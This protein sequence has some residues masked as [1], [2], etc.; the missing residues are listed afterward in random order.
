M[1]N[2]I[3]VEHDTE[4]SRAEEIMFERKIGSLFV[5]KNKKILG[6]VTDKDLIKDIRPKYLVSEIVSKCL[7]TINE[8]ECFD[9]ALDLMRE[10]QITKLPVINNQ[11]ALV[12]IVSILDVLKGKQDKE[13]LVQL[14]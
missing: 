14:S 1:K 2:P 13:Q 5:I 7:V 12:G 8:E 6:L 9:N 3:A 11:T 10:K 4:I